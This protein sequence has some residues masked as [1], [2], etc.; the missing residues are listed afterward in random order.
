MKKTAKEIKSEYLDAIVKI[1]ESFG[2]EVYQSTASAFFEINYS[3][4]KIPEIVKYLISH[5]ISED[6]LKR[7]K[8]HTWGNE[9]NKYSNFTLIHSGNRFTVGGGKEPY[10]CDGYSR[11]FADRLFDMKEILDNPKPFIDYLFDMVLK[12]EK[13]AIHQENEEVEDRNKK[14]DNLRDF[15]D[16][17]KELE[18]DMHFDGLMDFSNVFEYRIDTEGIIIHRVSFVGMNYLGFNES[19]KATPEFLELT[20]NYLKAVKAL[21]EQGNFK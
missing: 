20:S 11:T 5:G 12:R 16:R 15:R 3:Y 4:N 21:K 17:C 8:T 9:T 14:V 13:Q 1:I 10:I 2:F 7:I 18:L 6:V 19:I